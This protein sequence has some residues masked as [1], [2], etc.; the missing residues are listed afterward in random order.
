[1]KAIKWFTKGYGIMIKILLPVLIISSGCTKQEAEPRGLNDTF[2]EQILK[3]GIPHEE[4]IQL[5]GF[6]RFAFYVV[7]EHRYITDGYS[8]GDNFLACYATLTFIDKQTFIMDT[9]EYIPMEPPI[10]YRKISIRGE[11]TPGGQVKFYWPGSWHELKS[12]FSGLE[13]RT[14]IV[15][16]VTEH[17]G[18]ILSGPGISKNTLLYMGSF[19]GEKLFA[20]MHLTGIQTEPGTMPFL[21]DIIDGPVQ[22]NFMFDL[23]I[24]E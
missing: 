11:M 2:N 16:Q 8:I 1:M 12:D 24:S 20:D 13:S 18:M 22:I 4:I 6:T 14:N 19:D 17:T 3:K 5:Q 7:K 10:L 15:A 21:V 23:E 9:E